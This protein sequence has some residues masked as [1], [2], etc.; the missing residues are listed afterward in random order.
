MYHRY[1]L[2]R[3]DCNAGFPPGAADIFT[4][5]ITAGKKLAINIPFEAIPEAIIPDCLVTICE[6]HVP[7]GCVLKLK[8][9]CCLTD[10][11]CKPFIIMSDFSGHSLILGSSDRLPVA[12]C[13]TGFFACGRLPCK[14]GKSSCS[15]TCTVIFIDL[16]IDHSYIL[17]SLLRNV[18]DCLWSSDNSNQ[19]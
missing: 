6:L 17:N 7:T 5:N 13:L 16:A 2:Y 10:K 9:L 8:Q 19:F 3:R 18:L 14:Y 1:S 15:S 4:K 11:L 12:A